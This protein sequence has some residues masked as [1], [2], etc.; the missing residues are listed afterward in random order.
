VSELRAL[1]VTPLSG[2]LAGFGRST[3]A[4]LRLWADQAAELPRPWR[5]VRL[6]VEDAHP[7]PALAMQRGL[8]SQPHLI[9]GPYGSGP[10]LQA[11]GTT[12]RVVWNHGGAVSTIRWPAFPGVL[13]VLAPASTYF[14]GILEA[15]R[16][17]EPEPEGGAVVL[18][19]RTGFGADVARGAAAAASR[20]G[21]RTTAIAFARGEAGRAASRVPD[22][23]VLLV[24][25]SF[26]DELA[27]AR[28]LLQRPWRAAGFV[29]A[30][31][32]EVLAP[33]G[34]TREGLLGPTQWMASA[35]REP[36]EGPDS[37]WFATRYRSAVG[38]PPPY[39]AAQAF[40]AGVL[41]A[42]CLRGVETVDDA[43]QLTA[44]RRLVCRTLYGRFQLDP[45]TGLQ[46][47]HRVLTVQW[48]D[49]NRRIVWP[50]D[51]AERPLLY[52]LS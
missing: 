18:H 9:F 20:L 4:A 21:F 11:L 36:D 27:A 25:G 14:Q 32:D 16:S 35:G 23:D 17:V 48:Q 46:V 8:A 22:A 7:H 5:A 3:A 45:A 33:L 13:N 44:A 51:L 28:V 29:G 2:P 43:G 6:A 52:P 37:Q 1:V 49:G 38:K 12:G 31:V 42:R 19:A 39:P 24:A 34:A 15:V 26:E 50:R 10:T 40:A 47:G 41:A 30:G